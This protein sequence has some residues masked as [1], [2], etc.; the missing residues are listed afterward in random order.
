[1]NAVFDNYKPLH[2]TFQ[3][4]YHLGKA[5]FWARS[6]RTFGYIVVAILINQ[7]KESTFQCKVSHTV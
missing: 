6:T 7:M 3:L 4:K 5:L 1:M 2:Y